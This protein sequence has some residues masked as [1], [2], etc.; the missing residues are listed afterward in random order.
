MN[1]FFGPPNYGSRH[2][3]MRTPRPEVETDVLPIELDAATLD[4][5]T[6][7]CRSIGRSDI[8][9]CAAEVFATL[10]W[11]D[12]FAELNQEPSALH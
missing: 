2:T 5:F 8:A 6:G 10:V 7:Y 11:D 1:V 12:E 4:R 9:R 3:A